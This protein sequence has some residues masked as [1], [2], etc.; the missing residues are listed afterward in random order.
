MSDSHP[1][2]EAYLRLCILF[3]PVTALKPGIVVL[4]PLHEVPPSVEYWYSSLVVPV[5]P[6]PGVVIVIVR[7]IPAHT[8]A[9]PGF[10]AITGATGSATTV[11]LTSLMSDSQPEPDA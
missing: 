3:D 6:L 8:S 1:G 4:H 5:P 11:Q 10:F 2:P 9:T 7:V